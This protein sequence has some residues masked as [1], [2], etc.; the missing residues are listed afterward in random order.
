VA[1]SRRR[2]VK[3][4]ATRG[5][6]AARRTAARAAARRKAGDAGDMA[7]FRDGVRTRASTYTDRKREA[8]RRA[9]RRPVA[10]TSDD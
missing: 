10:R 7:R 8:S 3:G 1:R 2:S 9:C 4:R 6:S 5:T